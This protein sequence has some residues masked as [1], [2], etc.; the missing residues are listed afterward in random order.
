MKSDRQEHHRLAQVALPTCPRAHS[1]QRSAGLPTAAVYNLE[2]CAD[3]VPRQ[4]KPQA[5]GMAQRTSLFSPGAKRPI[6]EDAFLAR[7]SRLN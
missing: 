5:T 2:N 7:L 6:E 3:P 4:P 1:V